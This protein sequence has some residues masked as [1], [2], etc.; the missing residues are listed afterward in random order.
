M[1]AM[2]YDQYGSPDVL[3][4]EDAPKPEPKDDEVL[5]KVVASSINDWDWG[6]LR[7]SPFLNRMISGGLRKPGIRIMGVDVAGVVE[8]VGSAVTRHKPGDAVMGDL[9]ES[10]FGGY[11][12]YT[13]AKSSALLP[14]PPSLSFEQ[15]A[16]V[17]HVAALAI[18]ALQQGDGVQAGQRVLLNGAGGG[19]GTIGIQLA[20]LYGAEVTAVDS[21]AKLEVLRDLGADHVVDYT[22]EDVTTNGQRYDLIADPVLFRSVLDYRRALKADGRYVV[23]GGA[24]PRI[25]QTLIVGAWFARTGG[26]KM[27]ILAHRPN[28]GLDEISAL[29]EEGKVR[30]ILDRTYP[31]HDLPDAFRWYG[32]KA[33]IGK[34]IIRVA[35]DDRA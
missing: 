13:C 17:P 1:K 22:Q 25:L 20:K 14:K 3:R 4:L 31:L 27:G 19:M 7:G 23:V 10:G 34:I 28:K 32:E 16:A 18:Q 12:E 15:A 29:V 11:A 2:V 24:I 35:E 5:V 9:S 6:L 21:T 33:F 26:P 8:A 30:P